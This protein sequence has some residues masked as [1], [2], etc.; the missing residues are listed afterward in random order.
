MTKIHSC[1]SPVIILISI[2]LSSGTFAQWNMFPRPDDD[3]QTLE[4]PHFHVYFTPE[5]E[6]WT[7]YAMQRME[8]IHEAVT[9]YVGYNELKDPISIFIIDPMGLPNGMAI[10]FTKAPRIVLWPNSPV[11]PLMLGGLESWPEIVMVHEYGHIVHL[12]RQNRSWQGKIISSLLPVGSL[13]TKIPLWVTEGYAVIIESELT[14]FG[15]TQSSLRS[16]V[17][18]QLALEGKIPEYAELNGANQWMGGRYPYLVGSAFLEWL[19]EKHQKPDCLLHLWKRLTAKEERGFDEAFSGVFQ[20]EPEDLYD[21][22]RAE[23]ILEALLL[24]DNI[25]AQDT[26]EDSKWQYLE[27]LTGNTAVSPD[28]KALALV[29]RPWKSPPKLV[30]W[31]LDEVAEND[32]DPAL[33]DLDDVPGLPVHPQKRKELYSFLS[34]HGIIPAGP[35]WMPDGTLLFHAYRC[36]SNGDFRSD[37]YQ[38]W[39]ESDKLKRITNGAALCWADPLPDG[40]NAVCL[41]REYGLSG[42]VLLNLKTGKSKPLN[43]PDYR[44]VWQSPRV[45]PDG[46]SV[47]AVQRKEHHSELISL[48]LANTSEQTVLIKGA[49][50]EVILCPAWSP[51][52]RKIYYCSDAGGIMNIHTKDIYTG[53]SSVITRSISGVLSPEPLVSDESLFFIKPHS[54]GMD[55]HQLLST[56]NLP[57]VDFR[58][59]YKAVL[60][61]ENIKI[62]EPFKIAETGQIEKY[63]LWKSL[64]FGFTGSGKWLPYQS[65]SEIGFWMGDILGRFRFMALGGY[66]WNGGPSGGSLNLNYKGFPLHTFF[67]GFYVDQNPLEQRMIHDVSVAG[68]AHCLTGLEISLSW[69]KLGSNS[70]LVLRGGGAFARY[71][72]DLSDLGALNRWLGG[73]EAMTGLR[74]N[75]GDFSFGCSM[76]IGGLVGTTDSNEWSQYLG[77]TAG[78]ITWKEKTIQCKVTTGRIWGDSTDM[79]NFFLG[80]SR[81]SIESAWFNKNQIE[82]PWLPSGSICGD[83]FERFDFNLMMGLTSPLVMNGSQVNVW[84]DSKPDPQ[85]V[86]GIEWRMSFPDVPLF[87]VGATEVTTGVAYGI[88]GLIEDDWRGYFSLR[89]IP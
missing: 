72:P 77:S 68:M 73:L 27:G 63:N 16:M 34:R 39:P 81:S 65:S 20:D 45:S 78:F 57:L 18:C 44:T 35:R 19:R 79:D 58:G 75:Y 13:A 43:I 54:K 60:P 80:G 71:D 3:W 30:V 53:E 61:A 55:I 49:D 89:L 40:C 85:R 12:T 38:W 4:T 11:N 62:V 88:D 17:L 9:S 21:R 41:Y 70:N 82:I 48:S 26:H 52:G 33:D 36:Q 87:R 83:K 10:P 1:F 32:P 50:R 37:I 2:T 6:P 46:T 59:D 25:A 15:R 84:S 47:I 42:L 51:D 24:E 23:L 76:E 64:E 74:G 56:T 29:I 22:F 28:G 8:S 69:R 66:G 67:K 31:S 5:L 86:V 14:G 7:R